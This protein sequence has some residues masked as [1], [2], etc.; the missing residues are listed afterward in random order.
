[1]ALRSVQTPYGLIMVPEDQAASFGLPPEMVL[2][3]PSLPPPPESPVPDVAMAAPPPDA[4]S[5]VDAPP[6]PQLTPGLAALVAPPV[7]S[8]PI[9]APAPVDPPPP[10]AQATES[11]APAPAPAPAKSLSASTYDDYAAR[12][13]ADTQAQVAASQQVGEAEAASAEAQAA[14]LAERDRVMA[15]RLGEMEARRKADE[16]AVAQKAA[17]WEAKQNE[18][19]NAKVTRRSMNTGEMLG[20]LIAGL[21]SAMKGQGANNP[22]LPLIMGKIQ[23]DVEDQMRERDQLGQQANALKGSV[24][25]AREI[26]S[27]AQAQMNAA[28]GL[29]MQKHANLAETVAKKM[30]PGIKRAAMEQTAAAL[31]SEGTAKY[32]QALQLQHGEDQAAAARAQQERESRRSAFVAMRGQDLSMESRLAEIAAER[33]ARV[34]KAQT[35][36]DKD[37][38]AREV[39]DLYSVVKGPD[40]QEERVMYRAR[41]DKAAEEVAVLKASRD[42][43]DETLQDAIRIRGKFGSFA[44]FKNS[45]EYQQYLSKIT[46]SQLAFG[47]LMGTGAYDAGTAAALG[48]VYGGKP[49][50]GGKAEDL[51]LGMFSNRDPGPGVDSARGFVNDKFNLEANARRDTRGGAYVP[52]ELAS[53]EESAPVKTKDDEAVQSFITGKTPSDI[54]KAAEPGLAVDAVRAIPGLGVFAQGPTNK[55]RAAEARAQSVEDFGS[56]MTLT[57]DQAKTLDTIGAKY[58]S[59]DPAKVA[60][61]RKQ[62]V[63]AAVGSLNRG[64][65]AKAQVVLDQMA[66]LGD[67]EGLAEVE[68]AITAGAKSEREIERKREPIRFARVQA[69]L[70]KRPIYG[71]AP[72]GV[73]QGRPFIPREGK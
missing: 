64:Q 52:L 71:P 35:D 4:V 5:G 59:G 36:A 19:M 16:Q 53:A 63:A 69:E 25:Y 57:K 46:S 45:P 7:E 28:L 12:T 42:L 55:Q 54:R 30:E 70:M 22:A 32:G 39:A 11:A 10:P 15:E 51:V 34:A 26:A 41:S 40:G 38:A 29:E 31:R 9:A 13:D 73:P 18:W 33:E 37:A 68:Q 67:A 49:F 3:T 27:N 8:Q 21:G 72:F 66:V 61:A 2:G 14:I 47:R 62:M 50:A 1:M 48:N 44:A 58:R 6:A 60:D 43:I 23:Q 17:V 65:V 24:D 20:A 56:G